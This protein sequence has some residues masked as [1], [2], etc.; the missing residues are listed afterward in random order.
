ME[1][2]IADIATIFHWPLSEMYG[3]ELNELI[4][5][6]ERAAIRSGANQDDES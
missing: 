5:W 2:L 3:M 4:A 1:D 6:R